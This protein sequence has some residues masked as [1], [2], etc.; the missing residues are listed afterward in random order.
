MEVVSNE[1]FSPQAI[2]FTLG[3]IPGFLKGL[4]R[5]G[6]DGSKV[7]DQKLLAGAVFGRVGK[8]CEEALF[9]RLL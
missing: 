8:V 1:P 3:P 2:D 7:G 4:A 6:L 5:L 9:V